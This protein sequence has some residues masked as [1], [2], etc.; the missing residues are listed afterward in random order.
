[1]TVFTDN[2][3]NPRT[4]QLYIFR[5]VNNEYFYFDTI[6]RDSAQACLDT[7][8]TLYGSNDNEYHWTNPF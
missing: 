6:E 2:P 1:M 8:E 5:L 3:D 4:Y 7:A